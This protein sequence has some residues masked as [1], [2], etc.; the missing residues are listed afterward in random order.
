[1]YRMTYA[2]FMYMMQLMVDIYKM[3]NAVHKHK[4]GSAVRKRIGD[5][6][7]FTRAAPKPRTL[8]QQYTYTDVVNHSAAY[9]YRRPGAV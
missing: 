2:I 1:M 9:A 5:W 6:E 7:L 8:P 4:M 3:A